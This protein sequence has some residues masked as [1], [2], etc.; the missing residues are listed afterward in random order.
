MNIGSFLTWWPV[1]IGPIGHLVTARLALAPAVLGHQRAGRR[2]RA[3]HQVVG[4][5]RVLQLMGLSRWA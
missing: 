3:G 5:V 4:A 1:D 2:L